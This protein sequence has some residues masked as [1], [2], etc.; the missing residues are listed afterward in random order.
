M[1]G[2]VVRSEDESTSWSSTMTPH[3]DL[4]I[5]TRPSIRLREMVRCLKES[6]PSMPPQWILSRH[7]MALIALTVFCACGDAKKSEDSSTDGQTVV[8]SP[9][10]E[11]IQTAWD[12]YETTPPSPEMHALL[13]EAAAIYPHE[14][15]IPFDGN[16]MTAAEGHLKTDEDGNQVLC[17]WHHPAGCVPEGMNYAEVVSCDDVRTN[18]PSWFIPP[19][20]KYETE[21]SLFEDEDYLKELAWTRSQVAASG[22]ACCHSSDVSNYASMFD[23]DAPGSWT[24]TLTM[25]AIVMGAGLATEHKYLGFLPPETNF[26]FDRETTIFASTDVPR[27]QAFFKG[28]FE[29]RGGTEEDIEEA[30]DL[31][32]QIN[33][34]LLN[35]PTECRTD[36]GMDAE[37]RLIWTGGPARQ[38]YIQEL[39]A[40]NPGS[41]PTRD[42][43]EG[44]V[45]ALYSNPTANAMESGQIRVGTPPAGAEQIIPNDQSEAPVFE[46]GR[47][48][49]LFITPDFISP[50]YTNCTFTFGE[51][52]VEQN[53]EDRTCETDG[54]LCLTLKVPESL[55]ETPEKL[56]VALYRSLPP[57]GPPDVFP[58][59]SIDTPDLTP[60]GTFDVLMDAG[61]T[62]TYQVY[63]VFYMPGGGLASW[64]AAAGVDYIGTTEPITLDGP[65]L[66][67]TEPITMGLME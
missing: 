2:C 63:A 29:R 52:A 1:T 11:D 57:L 20:R 35:A 54:S 22:C 33:G 27:M 62:G 58:P 19:V 53:P 36:E 59:F 46:T 67:L 15:C 48:Y 13:T 37:G 7:L 61:A 28:E 32:L 43:P 44:T 66:T 30:R 6:G 24:D 10:A 39:G 40:E 17:V 18:G 16:T 56:V 26:G 50:A 23:I 5:R 34:S 42:R 3:I 49:R 38:V 60:G 45:W 25:T 31:F 12:N 51:A 55:S 9:S 41:P 14:E 65:G 47:Q 64:Q 4:A 8:A 21:P